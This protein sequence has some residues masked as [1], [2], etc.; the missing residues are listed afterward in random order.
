ML[1]NRFMS[2]AAHRKTAQP[3]EGSDFPPVDLAAL[4]KQRGM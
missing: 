1:I 3:P 4:A 2:S